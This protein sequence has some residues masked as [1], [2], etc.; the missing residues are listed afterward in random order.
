M[1]RLPAILLFT[2]GLFYTV[3]LRAQEALVAALPVDTLSQYLLP[4]VITEGSTFHVDTVMISGN[5]R[6]RNAVILREIS[7]SKNQV[8]NEKELAYRIQDATDRLMNT[9]LFRRVGV[10]PFATAGDHIAIQIDVEEKW[11]LYPM[12]FVRVV[13]G[14]FEQWWNDRGR[15]LDQLNYGIRLSQFNAT[16]RNDNLYL[17]IM[18]GYTRQ[19]SLEYRNLVLDSALKWHAGFSVSH[20][21]NREINYM[22]RNDKLMAVKDPHGYIRSFTQAGVE[23]SYRPALRTRHSFS[24]GYNYNRIGDTVNKLNASFA[25]AARVFSYPS[26]GYNL[27]YTNVDFVPYPTRGFFGEASL[28]HSG[29]GGDINLWQLALKGN[30]SFPMGKKDFLNLRAVG[31]VKL[32]FEQPYINQQFLGFN[33]LYLQGYE[34]YV[35]DGVAGGYVKL[36]YH[37]P[38]LTTSITPPQNQVTSKFRLLQP[39]PLKVYAKAFANA[40]YV[41]HPSSSPHNQ[42]NNRMLYTAGIGLD[43][44]AFADLIVKLEWSFNQLGQNGLYLHQRERF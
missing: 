32:P 11:Y 20:G 12:P 27:S 3:S 33:D 24:F 38:L 44:I 40:G 43:V 10:K 15:S 41:H 9:G 2:I 42:L 31:M 14:R 22:T 23:I 28:T 18:S 13:D 17:N 25:N 34:N 19:L 35:V 29:F 30:T 16:G 4:T 1:A 5:N 36:S 8:L 26:A 21:R 37:K 39:V 7:F 6:T